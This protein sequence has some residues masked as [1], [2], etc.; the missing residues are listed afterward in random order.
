M[1][2]L[3]LIVSGYGRVGRALVRLLL[4]K[5]EAVARRHGLELP[6]AAVVDVDGAA[7]ASGAA[8]LPLG[9][10]AAGLPPGKGPSTLETWGEPSVTTSVLVERGLADVLVETTPTDLQTGE[11][12]LGHLRAALSHGLHVVTATK[13]PL[14]LRFGELNRLAERNGV[15]LKYSAATAAALPALDLGVY[16]LAGAEIERIEG[17]LNGTTNFILT[18][19]RRL[20]ETY[21]EAL[22]EAQRLGI[23]E[24]DPRLDVGGWD[25]ASKLVLIAN[26]LLGVALTLD[27][28]Q[29]SGI[30]GVTLDQIRGAAAAG[31]VPRLLAVAVRD[32]GAVRASVGVEHLAPDHPLAAV[33]G[34]EKGIT[35]FTDTM[36]RVTVAGGKSD[37]RGAAAALLKDLINLARER[38]V[39]G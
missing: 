31:V 23:A 19:M 27:Q 17:V 33:D 12:G 32:G 5:G 37:P 26:G 24:A 11:P 25:T 20:E 13:G 10:I 28:V 29:V 38:G 4:E 34:A 35:Y 14:V 8:G 15:A 7:V 9:Q 2:N 6:L 18:R 21:Q 36:D 30:E 22:A 1:T 16:C 39:K 3:R